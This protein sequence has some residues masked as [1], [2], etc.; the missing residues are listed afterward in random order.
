MLYLYRARHKKLHRFI[1]A[2]ALWE[3]HLLRHFWHKCTSINF[4]S[5]VYSIFFK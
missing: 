3:L 4:L 1:F 2:I 5:S